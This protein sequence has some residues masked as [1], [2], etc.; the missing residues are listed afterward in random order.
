MALFLIIN[1]QALLVLFRKFV[2]ECSSLRRAKIAGKNKRN[3]KKAIVNLYEWDEKSAEKE[4]NMDNLR[5]IYLGYLWRNM[6][7][8]QWLNKMPKN[9]HL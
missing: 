2:R 7:K 3:N 9:R 6:M 1:L 5:Y 8:R 4:L